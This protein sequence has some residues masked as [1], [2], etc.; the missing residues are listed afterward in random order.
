MT[1]GGMC[2]DG[3][4]IEGQA[5]TGGTI[6]VAIEAAINLQDHDYLMCINYVHLMSLI[7]VE[8]ELFARS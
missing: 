3:S 1:E 4:A 5:G 8:V 2:G 7:N 6:R